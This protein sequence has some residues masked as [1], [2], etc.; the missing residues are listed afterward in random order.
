MKGITISGGEPLC[1]ENIEGVT[2]FIKSVKEIK[3]NF[4]VWCYT[5]YTLE[6]LDKRDDFLTNEALQQIDVLVDGRYVEQQK[7]PTLKFR[8]SI[9][10][11]VIDVKKYIQTKQITQLAI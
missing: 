2:D 4:N 7:D 10:Q 3:P 8:G 6:E 1:K 5:G 11:R 9:N